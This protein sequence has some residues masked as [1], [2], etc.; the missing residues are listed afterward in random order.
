MNIEQAQQAV[1]AARAKVDD[2]EHAAAMVAEQLPRARQEFEAAVA[3]L[4][5]LTLADG[6]A[7]AAQYQSEIERLT[8][9]IN[10]A[11]HGGT[12]HV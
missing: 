4:R 6:T 9:A 5:R 3:L 11:R 7:A 1:Q 8:Q 2:L 10:H 12:S